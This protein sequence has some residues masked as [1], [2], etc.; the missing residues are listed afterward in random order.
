M[1]NI[2]SFSMARQRLRSRRD[3]SDCSSKL[4]SMCDSTSFPEERD[5]KVKLWALGLKGTHD[6]LLAFGTCNDPYK[7]ESSLRKHET[8]CPLKALETV[9][10]QKSSKRRTSSNASNSSERDTIRLKRKDETKHDQLKWK[11]ENSLSNRLWSM[12]RIQTRSRYSPF[13]AVNRPGNKTGPRIRDPCSVH[14]FFVDDG[15]MAYPS[16]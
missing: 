11:R 13:P 14:E 4:E 7:I 6:P 16:L 9:N 1:Y 10:G 5:I 15:D 8:N 2:Q 3:M 12:N